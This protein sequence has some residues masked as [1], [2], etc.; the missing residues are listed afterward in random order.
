MSNFT[1][2]I[3]FIERIVS[4]WSKIE[5]QRKGSNAAYDQ[6]PKTTY[7]SWNNIDYR[8]AFAVFYAYNG[9]D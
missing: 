3:V 5:E 9:Q 4:L 6:Y 7:N 8:H 2:Q 1:M